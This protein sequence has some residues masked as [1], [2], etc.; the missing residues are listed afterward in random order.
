MFIT[1]GPSTK[2]FA[3]AGGGYWGTCATRDDDE[4]DDLFVFNDTI[5]LPRAPAVNPGRVTLTRVRAAPLSP[6]VGDSR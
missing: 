2:L 4:E 3:W 1:A 6:V 5:E